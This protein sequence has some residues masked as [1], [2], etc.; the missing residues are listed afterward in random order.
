M[1]LN[2]NATELR[3]DQAARTVEFVDLR[4][5]EGRQ[6]RVRARFFVLACGGI[7]NARLMLDSNRV[8][9][10]GLGNRH[11]L[12]GRYFMEHPIDRVG[13]VTTD[14]PFRLIDLFRPGWLG[15][16]SYS[17]ALFC[18][19]DKRKRSRYSIIVFT[20]CSKVMKRL[21]LLCGALVRPLRQ[22]VCRTG[23][24]KGSGS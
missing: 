9:P 12:V 19:T 1:L 5:L 16:Q 8:E 21:R 22:G 13:S 3:T 20:L 10:H 4:S 17:P 7:E 23:W 14:D 18:P 11:D 6:A 2:A 15:E 24:R